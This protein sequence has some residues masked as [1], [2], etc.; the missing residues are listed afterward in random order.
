ML[1][2]VKY[3]VSLKTVEAFCCSRVVF[4][5]V[6][7]KILSLHEFFDNQFIE[8]TFLRYKGKSKKSI[9]RECCG[10]CDGYGFYD[11]IVKLTD[12]GN[13]PLHNFGEAINR[14][15]I[16]KNENPIS[17]ILYDMKPYSR[18]SFYYV[19]NFKPSAVTYRC[20]RCH[21]TGLNLEG[22]NIKAFTIEDLEP[23]TIEDIP[24]KK[25]GLYKCFKALK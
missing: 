16:V 10:K 14:P 9:L 3:N 4:N 17:A 24:E 23:M 20:E 22:R 7:I 11:W 15:I 6:S 2:F 25:G 13:E 19:T 5:R 18:T 12:V 8:K 1:R 21:G